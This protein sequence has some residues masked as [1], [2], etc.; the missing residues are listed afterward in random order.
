[1][2]RRKFLIGAGGLTFL[3]TAASVFP[4]FSVKEEEDA[5][6]HAPPSYQVNAWVHLAPDGSITIMNPAAEMGQGSM[7][8]LAVLI[9]EE[10]DADWSKVR[11]EHSPVE[12]D[13]YGLKFRGRG[14]GRMITVGSFTV[15]GYFDA[16][17][18]AG[19]QARYV[20]LSN[21]AEKWQV[22]LSELR[23][24]PSLVVHPKS[25]RSI[26]YGEVAT[27]A[28]APA[29]LPEIGEEQLKQPA[30]FRLIGTYMPRFDI[31]AKT[32]GSGQFAMDV[33]LPGMVYAV[34]NRSPVHGAKPEL[35]N[36]TELKA[37]EGVLEVVKLEHG[38]GVIAD[39]VEAALA[40]K[41]QM[42]IEWSKGA[43]AYEYDSE[44]A[45]QTYRAIAVQEHYAGTSVL[46]SQ[47]D[48]QAALAKAQ[49][50]FEADYLNDFVYHAQ[51]EPLNAV[52]SVAADG[53]S[54]EVWAGTQA[55]AGARSA[56]AEVLGLEVS[57][58]HFHPCYLGGGFGR[59]SMS[60]YIE[61]AAHLAKHIRRPLKLL[62]TREDDVQYGAFRPMSLQRMQAGV[63]AEG[64]LT[65]WSHCIVGTGNRLLGSGARNPYY[66]IPNQQIEV[67]NVEHGIRTKHWRAVGHGPNKFAI[68]AFLD[69]IATAL[70]EDPVQ[71]RLRLM[72]NAPRAAAVLKA[73]AEMAQWGR[74]APAGRARGLAFAE[75]SGALVAGICEISL[76]A[77]TGKIRV[78][79]FWAAVDAG[80]VVQ[81]ENTL[82]QMEGGIVHGISSVLHE[83]ITFSKGQ[84]QQSNF[85]NYS[86]LRMA[87]TPESIA[88]HI[89]PSSE[90]PAGIGEAS[91]PVVGGAIA[92]AF[93]AL[94]GKR[95]RHLPFTPERVQQVL[96]G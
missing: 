18:K 33:V 88:V 22:P 73:A 50:R 85:H 84:V 69:E 3:V 41:K 20:L 35:R 56:V 49:R 32:D 58:V 57:Q 66:D 12:P 52:V 86:L 79:H 4:G 90:K 81:P 19:A 46:V 30:Q 28:K 36:E 24:E 59:R 61:E 34:I 44:S 68:E 51:M 23:T 74:A 95:L 87:D 62:W 29:T 64:K 26:S 96:E 94:T 27:F 75:R 40:A 70:Q 13:I 82:A 48:A 31:P 93:A 15:S 38:V 43:K 71:L 42:Q 60:D 9:A 8:A 47:G 83:R 67:R 91:L 53:R 6:P 10:L 54:A 11:I 21:V 63:D 76:K 65:T 2:S 78:H 92:N 5:S 77:D 39:S 37:A 17:R 25:G 1:M 14:R 45:P 89:M 16:L 80:I 7:T 72:K 55:S